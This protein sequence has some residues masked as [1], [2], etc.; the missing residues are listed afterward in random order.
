MDYVWT[1]YRLYYGCDYA[2]E[3]MYGLYMDYVWNMFETIMV[4]LV[5]V[6]C[7]TCIACE[8]CICDCVYVY[9]AVN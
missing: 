6:V 8:I 2:I 5:N 4:L 3:T 9:F 1:M 7:E